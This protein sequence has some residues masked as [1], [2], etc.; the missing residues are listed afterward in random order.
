VLSSGQAI[1][2]RTVDKVEAFNKVCGI[3]FLVEKTQAG[4]RR[5]VGRGRAD[6]RHDFIERGDEVIKA[7]IRRRV[8]KWL[9]QVGIR[10][11]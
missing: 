11:R 8:Q 4:R 3:L 5:P 7:A 9:K 6:R 2:Y 1:D 10:L